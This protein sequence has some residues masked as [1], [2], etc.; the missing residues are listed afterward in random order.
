MTSRQGW[1][2]SSYK[3]GGF[4]WY[5]ISIILNVGKIFEFWNHIIEFWPHITACTTW[6]STACTTWY[7]Q[8]ACTMWYSHMVLCLYETCPTGT[9]KVQKRPVPCPKDR[10]YTHAGGLSL[11]QGQALYPR[12]SLSQSALYP[13]WSLSQSNLS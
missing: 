9:G 11:S 13:R 7:R 3:A 5:Q 1:E 8:S 10:S 2:F 4:E 6:Y 12:W